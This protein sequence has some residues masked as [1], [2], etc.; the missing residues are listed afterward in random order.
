MFNRRIVLT[1]F[2]L[3]LAAMLT[4]PSMEAGANLA[5]VN[6][7][8]FSAPVALPGV[9]LPPGRYT[10]EAG[11]LAAS[12]NIVR[13]LSADYQK[14]DLVGLTQHVRR[15]AGMAP[16]QIVSMGEAPA[17]APAPIRAWYPIGSRSVTS[18]GTGRSPGC[19]GAVTL[20]APLPA[21]ILGMKTV[22]NPCGT[23]S[24]S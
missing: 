17:G 9:V 18:F 8:T 16:N 6:H 23:G 14:L 2:V 20:F 10:F 3:V 19:E 1:A 22:S 11:P 15:P 4:A 13:V 5:T 24:K 21:I 12:S 7:V